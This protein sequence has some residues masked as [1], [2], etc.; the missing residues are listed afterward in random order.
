MPRELLLPEVKPLTAQ[1]KTFYEWNRLEP[2]EEHL[3]RECW[4]IKAACGFVKRKGR[5][6]EI[7]K[8]P[9]PYV[10]EFDSTNNNILFFNCMEVMQYITLQK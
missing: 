4:G 7:P 3:Y 1:L 6:G 8:V 2:S 5:R 9:W 10:F